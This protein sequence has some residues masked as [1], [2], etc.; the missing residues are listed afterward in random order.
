MMGASEIT[1]RAN[2]QFVA[3][4]MRRRCSGAFTT[5]PGMSPLRDRRFVLLLAGQAVNG[6]GS[7]CALIA[8][9]G[10]AAY[11]FDASPAQIALLSL[12]WALPAAVF[13]PL[14][15][16]P[17]DRFG[18]KRALIAAD[19]VAAVVSIGLA[20][21][22]SFGQ[23]VALGTCFGLTRAVSDPAF[24]AL[25]PRL[26]DDREL[27]RANALLGAAMMS[28]I[29]FGPLLAA[30]AIAIW[31]LRAAFIADAVTYL[32]GNAVVIPLH[33]RELDRAP[34]EL[35]PSMLGELRAGFSFVRRSDFVRRVLLLA[36]SVYLVWGA[37]AVVE[38]IYV[39][40]VLH[41]SSST[42]ALLQAC[43]GAML[44]TNA[45][46]VSRVGERAATVRT[47]RISALLAAAAAPLYVG[48]SVV[49][50]A[51]CGVGLWGA[52][53]AWLIA[54]RDTLIQRATPVEAHGRV[55]AM[56]SALRS[57]AHVIALPLAAFLVEAGGARATGFVF[58]MVPLLG[59]WATRRAQAPVPVGG[60]EPAIAS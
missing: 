46:I 57:W 5:V 28:S 4:K 59:L 18:P 20:F 42:F 15:G 31:G 17:V 40:D 38:P 51:F 35:R 36:S 9:W 7:W 6:I 19:T 3:T 13:G 23:L 29:A 21:T 22:T 58:A 11:K 33:L 55:L 37:Y 25:A 12:S 50:L 14:G 54:P 32:I 48:T 49:G 44:L 53:T 24:S 39:R 56:D 27:L 41:R 8:M 60:L 10:Y 26:V 1:R 2:G 43:F 47:L 52:A 45:L 30:G 16:L 34:D